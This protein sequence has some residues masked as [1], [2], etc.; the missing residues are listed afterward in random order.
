MTPL[1]IRL[2]ESWLPPEVSTYVVG[3][4]VERDL[5]DAKL[6]LEA[7]A[8]LW[9]LGRTSHTGDPL[10]SSFIGDLRLA[11]RLLRRSPAFAIVSIMTLALG[12]GAT[13]AIYSVV[14]PVLLEPLPYPSPDRLVMV[15]ERNRDGTNDNVGFLTFHDLVEQSKTI[16]SAAA[17]GSWL[18]IIGAATGPERVIGDRVSWTYFRTLGVRPALGRDFTANEDR[19]GNNTVVVLGH[20]LWTKSFGSD[21]AIVGKSILING[22][23]MTVVGVMDAS[24][25]NV[26]SPDAQIW[27]V[28]G[29]DVTLPF[30]CRTCHHL[31]MIARLRPGV[32]HATAV[33]ELDAIHHRLE[34][35][36]PKEYGSVGASIVPVK[37]EAT[38]EYRPALLALAGAVLVMLLIAIAN[39]VSMQLAR[40]VRRD[41]EFAIRM[42]LGAGSRRLMRQ[43]VT[44]GLLLA[45]LGGVAGAIVAVAAVPL[46]VSRLPEQLPRLGEIHVDITALVVVGLIVLALSLLV[47]LAPAASRRIG[48]AG[49][50]AA[51]LRSGRRLAGGG[52]H[53]IRSGLVVGEVALALMLLVGCGLLARSMI[54]LL[55]VDTGFDPSHLLTLEVNSVGPRYPTNQSIFQY[56]D[57]VREAVRAVPGVVSV[58]VSNQLPLSGSFDMYGAAPVDRPLD[59]PELAPNGD[60]YVVSADFLKVMRIPIVAGRGFD[61]HD[62]R[63]S[64][65][66]VV[67]LSAALAGRLWPGENPLGKQVRFGGETA[68][69]RTVVGVTGNIRHHGLDE[70]STRQFYVPERQW[71]FADNQEALVVRTAADPAAVSASVRRAIAQIDPAQPIVK[72]ATMQNVIAASMAQ[73]RL[74][75]VL[76]VSF[77]ATALLLAIAGIYGV[78]A[79]RVAERTRE[80]GVRGALG[81]GPSDILVLVMG[82]GVRL[83]L[84][85]LALGLAGALGLTRFLSTMLFG[86]AATDPTTI[87]GV[88]ALL[89]VVIVGA[90][91]VPALRAVRID[92]SL[93][94]R[95]E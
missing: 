15:W 64:T 11:A 43:L 79:G 13:T 5:G 59:N 2:L 36:Y 35:A 93:A 89:F 60:R 94:M 69:A 50:L 44:E 67:L 19:Q 45:L 54:G 95:V 86:V 21:T 88:I 85:G 62:E 20:G 39:V 77:G 68:P 7:I 40:A 76:F 92:P 14:R 31:R 81:A 26:M 25:Q 57:R 3:D 1:P 53:A 12:I 78:L 71:F 33:A 38:R 24:F 16:Q 84:V 46:L 91:L 18:P 65:G 55:A 28:L 90:C 48:E 4:L 8:A 42:A 47:G 9:S 10:V 70:T 74:A 52:N 41:E 32:A 63:D 6:W 80:I 23:P 73:R 61:A 56:H 72:V 82:Q 30:A 87:G 37:D 49:D 27:R 34:S 83:A 51:T 29:Y 66:R 75:L 58:A 22:A 17:I